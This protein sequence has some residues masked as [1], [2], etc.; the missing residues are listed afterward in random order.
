MHIF[1]GI[2]VNKLTKLKDTKLINLLKTLTPDEM[3]SF[4]KFISSSYF[5]SVKNYVKLFKELEK[6]YPK[7]DDDKLTNEYIY[8]KLFK[9]KAFN[10]QI[11]W[12]LISGFEK[13]AREFLIQN[14]FAKLKPLKHTLIFGELENRDLD[15]L[16]VK[17]WTRW[18]K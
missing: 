11:M 15:K 12:N 16:F 4:A 17:R 1:K 10:K 7:F 9:A 8:K 13:L 3:K 18:K 6:F 14:A 5:N 2:S